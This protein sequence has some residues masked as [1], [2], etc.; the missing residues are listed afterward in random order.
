MCRRVGPKKININLNFKFGHIFV[1]QRSAKQI[2]A[3]EKLI[4]LI[5]RSFLTQS[6][7]YHIVLLQLT[8]VMKFYDFH[9]H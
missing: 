1:D 3:V 2:K 6:K 5:P 9:P 4:A 8:I 7:E